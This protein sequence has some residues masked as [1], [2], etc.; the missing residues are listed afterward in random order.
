[1]QC[2][3]VTDQG[4]FLGETQVAAAKHCWHINDFSTLM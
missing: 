4:A 3:S 2:P 1:M